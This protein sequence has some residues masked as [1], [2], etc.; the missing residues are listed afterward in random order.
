MQW[1]VATEI[2]TVTFISLPFVVYQEG[3]N[4]TYLQLGLVGSFIARCIV[5]YVLVPAY[6]RQSRTGDIFSPYDYMGQRLGERVRRMMSLLFTLGGILG[7]AARVYL[8]AL[9][10]EVILHHEFSVLTALWGIEPTVLSVVTI[11]VVAIGWTLLGGIA[12][13]VWTDAIL[14]LLFI[15]GVTLS[16][17]T[18]HSSIDGGLGHALT[19]ASHA[20]KLVFWDF[21]LDPTKAFTFWAALFAISWS[22][23]GAYGT[24][25]MLA[26]RLLCC[27]TENEARKAIITSVVGMGIT[28][29]VALVG[30][31][32]WSYYSAHPLTGEAARL[33]AERGDRIYPIFI[34][35]VI[36]PGLRGLV[37]AGAFAAAI[38]SL[39]S[40][41][42]ALSQTTL[43]AVVLP[44]RRKR[45]QLRG[46]IEERDNEEQFALAA[47]RRL[48]VFWGVTLMACAV[49]IE[50][51]ASFYDSILSLA[52]AMATYTSGALLA[53]FVIALT[54]RRQWVDGLM[55]S[56]PMSCLMIISLVWHQA[57]AVALIWLILGSASL[58]W[59]LVRLRPAM[60]SKTGAREAR[61][62]LFFGVISVAIGCTAS[63][64][65]GVQPDGS[66]LILAWPWYVP[67]GS[68]VALLGSKALSR[69]EVARSLT[70]NG[71]GP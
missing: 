30:V 56:A 64:A 42:A 21:D 8:T 65:Y 27:R 70:D 58:L 4:L 35:E 7:Q 66:Y 34:S 2:S 38:S 33:V 24:D 31:G 32:L 13:V 19:E 55:W 41:L 49:A 29:A 61:P 28:F 6:Y 36:P 14:F 22:G 18:L 52:L 57:T 16:L 51:A 11:G 10:L 48:V 69:P 47:S 26:Q 43:S 9:V 67:I 15:A 3:G 63:F 54:K 23:I 25:H 68:I 44:R 20:G 50:S 45:L 37:L 17:W 1:I 60:R 39:D 62:T 71:P 40:I 5:G 46:R 59:Y 53:G 12:T